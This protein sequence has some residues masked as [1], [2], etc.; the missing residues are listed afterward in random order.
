MVFLIFEVSE[1]DSFK[2]FGKL[3]SKTL[4]KQSWNT[5]SACWAFFPVNIL[6]PSFCRRL[7]KIIFLYTNCCILIEI[8]LKFVPRCPIDIKPAS[9]QKMA[10]CWT[11]QQTTSHYLNHSGLVYI[12]I[13]T[14]SFNELNG[15]TESP[16]P[17]YL[18]STH[19]YIAF[20]FVLFIPSV[21]T[22]SAWDKT[23]T[24]CRHHC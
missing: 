10:W 16:H 5:V 2:I 17:V 21:L 1:Q 18:K 4:V 7:F 14:F 9:V 11:L 6:R 24:L 22:H 23:A 20:C 3:I 15:V 12:Y 8:S 19:F 13:Y